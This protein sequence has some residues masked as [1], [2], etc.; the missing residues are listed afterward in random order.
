MIWNIDPVLLHLGPLEIRYYG[1][2]FA[3]GLFLAYQV[4]RQLVQKK[5]L[6]L[7]KLDSLTVYLIVG[8]ILGA[9]FGHIVF[10]E[11]DYYLSN[12]MQIL[13][14]WQGGLASHGAA[15]G[16]LVAYALFLWRNK[17]VKTFDYADIIVVVAALPISLIRLGN[18]FNSELYGRITDLP[19]AVTFSRID[20][21]ARHPSQLYEFGMGALLFVILYP[22]WLK[23]NKDMNP[24]FFVGLFFTLYFAMRF[25]VEFVKEFPLHE[26]FFNLTTGQMLSL[27]F[28]A[29]GLLILAHSKGLLGSVSK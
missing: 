7:E 11:L 3:L 12:P 21:L 24:G 10:Y 9:R 14:I 26:N 28:F 16:L 23:K 19:W 22:L 13:K 18:F 25:T 15:I 1:V 20:N 5:D 17:K 6:S 4:A 29:V 2:F 8:L 27:P